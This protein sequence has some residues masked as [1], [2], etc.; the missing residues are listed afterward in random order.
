MTRLHKFSLKNFCFTSVIIG[1]CLIIT[2]KAKAE[3]F[4]LRPGKITTTLDTIPVRPINSDSIAV[5]S[6]RMIDTIPGTRVDTFS[7]KMSKDTLDAPIEY[8]A[9]DSAVLLVKDKIFLLY[10]QTKTTYNDVVLTAPRVE[11]NQATNIVTA[12]NER[13]SL[14]NVVARARFQQ[15]EEG[16]QSDT[17]RFNFKTQKGLTQN[18]F[19]KQD[20]FF[21]NASVFKKIDANTTFAKRVIM[22]TCEFDEPHF[23]FVSSKGKFITN[24]IAVTGPIH[25]EF[26]E[27]RF[28]FIFLLAFFL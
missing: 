14:G 21:V 28:L 12:Y 27:F 24:K 22:T 3:G 8:E 13:D 15:G 1:F 4:Q 17:I 25:P 7:V 11:M 5:D 2:G 19:T 9:A 26:E 6:V 18:T 16:F 10:G 20:D 23:G